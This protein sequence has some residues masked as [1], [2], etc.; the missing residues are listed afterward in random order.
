M[1]E[2]DAALL[3]TNIKVASY[4]FYVGHSNFSFVNLG[5]Q[6]LQGFSDI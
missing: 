5:Y 1:R 3:L 4:L 2:K 6:L